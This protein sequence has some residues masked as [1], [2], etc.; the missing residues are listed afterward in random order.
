MERFPPLPIY[1]SHGVREVR[2]NPLFEWNL[3][4][5]NMCSISM[6]Q[7]AGV[8]DLQRKLSRGG[9]QLSGGLLAQIVHS[10]HRK[11]EADGPQAWMYRAQFIVT[12][13]IQPLPLRVALTTLMWTTSWGEGRCCSHAVNGRRFS[14][15]TLV[16]PASVNDVGERGSFRKASKVLT[17]VGSRCDCGHRRIKL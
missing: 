12:T 11:A 16:Y 8:N 15:G 5:P 17:H 9:I 1:H 7:I 6:L 14:V 4:G 13:Y 10:I 3:Y 2:H